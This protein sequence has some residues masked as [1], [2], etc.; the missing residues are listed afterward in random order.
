VLAQREGLKGRWGAGTLN[1]LARE[2]VQ[3]ARRGLERFDP[4]DAALLAPL[5]ERTASGRS[6]S[7]DVLETP[8]NP[9][10]IYERF[11]L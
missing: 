6:P 10:A 3:I 7:V 5:E 2:L 9:S 8:R 1:D 4:E 11:A